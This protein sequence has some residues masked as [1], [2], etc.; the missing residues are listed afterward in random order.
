[1]KEFKMKTNLSLLCLIF[2]ITSNFSYGSENPKQEK[3]EFKFNVSFL[4][5]CSKASELGEKNFSQKKVTIRG[6]NTGPKMTQE[7]AKKQVAEV[8]GIFPFEINCG[9]TNAEGQ[10]TC[11]THAQIFRRQRAEKREREKRENLRRK[12]SDFNDSILYLLREGS[13]S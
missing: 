3:N 9:Q 11:Y 8:L 12:L 5:T 10:Q 1:M 7:E 6:D 4:V 13:F 2:L